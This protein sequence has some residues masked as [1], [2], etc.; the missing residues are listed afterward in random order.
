MSSQSSYRNLFFNS[1]A[2]MIDLQLAFVS[3]RFLAPEPAKSKSPVQ[4][5]AAIS[6]EPRVKQA[7]EPARAPGV[8]VEDQKKL[9]SSHQ[10]GVLNTSGPRLSPLPVI[11][12]FDTDNADEPCTATAEPG[13][14]R[15][16][17]VSDNRLIG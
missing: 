6:F 9:R 8:T 12:Q 5:Q 17:P 1:L 10:A 11:G 4:A 14:G 7:V 3:G 16:R 13:L 2:T 15:S